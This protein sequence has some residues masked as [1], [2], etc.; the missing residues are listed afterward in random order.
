[1]NAERLAVIRR[2]NTAFDA[3]SKAEVLC[4]QRRKRGPIPADWLARLA[5]LE[6]GYKA[7]VAAMGGDRAKV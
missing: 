5:E 6:A 7:A 1:M 4:Y 2:K 3:L